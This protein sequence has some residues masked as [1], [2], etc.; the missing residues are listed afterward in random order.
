M[1]SAR[2]ERSFREDSMASSSGT[3]SDTAR[4]AAAA[5]AASAA[6]YEKYA[7]AAEPSTAERADAA[8]AESAAA[9]EKYVASRVKPDDV[10]LS[11]SVMG[12]VREFFGGLIRR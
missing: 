3:N 9:Y 6:A 11:S 1:I 8:A 4:T 5:A 7:V 12:R 2:L 10:G